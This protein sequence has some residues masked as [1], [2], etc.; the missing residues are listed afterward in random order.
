ME[1]FSILLIAL[2]LAMDS[3]AVSVSCGTQMSR[4]RT[5]Q[6]VVIAFTMGFFQAVMPLLGWLLGV[7]CVEWVSRFDHWIAFGLLL[8]LGVRMIVDA[9]KKE[10]SVKDKE[11]HLG[12]KVLCMMGIA[13]SI[14][15]LAVGVSFAMMGVE[16]WL[17]ALIIGLVTYV[18]SFAG[19]GI[20]YRFGRLKKINVRLIGG[21]ILIAIGL[22]ILISDLCVA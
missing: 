12:W 15:A 16:V 7:E 4:F 22:K 17:P 6:A 2:A 21:V 1:L 14:D 20:G 3:F 5:M 19:V 8:F 9:M 10:E 18:L 13:T 11:L